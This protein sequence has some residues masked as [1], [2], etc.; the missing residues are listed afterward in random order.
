MCGRDAITD[1]I[2]VFVSKTNVNKNKRTY[3]F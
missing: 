1:Q 3:E 2:H